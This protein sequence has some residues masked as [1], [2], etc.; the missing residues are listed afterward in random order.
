M[1]ISWALSLDSSVFPEHNGKPQETRLTIKLEENGRSEEAYID[2][3]LKGIRRHLGISR[4]PKAISFK[5]AVQAIPQYGVGHLE[6]MA[7]LKTQFSQKLPHCHLVG[8]YL[9]ELA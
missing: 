7:A 3:A 1:R 5:R 4:I 8:N 2:A 6:K 9:K